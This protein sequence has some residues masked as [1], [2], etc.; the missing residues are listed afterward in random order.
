MKNLK[1][2]LDAAGGDFAPHEMVKGAIKAVQ[3]YGVEVVLVGRK[4]VLRKLIGEV[5]D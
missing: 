1:I 4:N 2:A 3:E 5:A